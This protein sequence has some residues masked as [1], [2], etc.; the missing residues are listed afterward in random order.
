MQKLLIWAD[1]S[2]NNKTGIGGW[3]A[4]IRT[5]PHGKIKRLC[6][7]YIH[8]TNNQMEL[9][10]VIHALEWVTELGKYDIQ[11]FSDSQY[12][13]KGINEWSVGWI[14]NGWRTATGLPVK[15]KDLWI[16]LCALKP[17]HRIEFAWVRGH[18]GDEFNEE[19]DKLAREGAGYPRKV[20]K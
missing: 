2:C 1:G 16:S 15:N 14:R 10:A 3:G 17:K 8:T 9:L 20:R 6:G 7:G 12:V 4:V 13:I 19:A 5:N 11:L 18:N